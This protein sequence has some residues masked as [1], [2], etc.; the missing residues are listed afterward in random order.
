MSVWD[1][2]RERCE[3]RRMLRVAIVLALKME[4]GATS[5]SDR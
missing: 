3:D 4:E 2:D 1:S 5:S